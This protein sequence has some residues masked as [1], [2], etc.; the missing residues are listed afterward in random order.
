MRS[1]GLPLF[2]ENAHMETVVLLHLA[3]C[4]SRTCR[5][6]FIHLGY[7][8]ELVGHENTNEGFPTK[9]RLISRESLPTHPVLRYCDVSVSQPT[10]LRPMKNAMLLDRSLFDLS[11]RTRF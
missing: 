6:A 5:H 10:V 11:G 1:F 4:L 7:V 2:L 3:C 8:S 9:I